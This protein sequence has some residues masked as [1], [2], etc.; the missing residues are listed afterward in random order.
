MTYEYHCHGL[1]L[2][3][4]QMT[5]LK[6]AAVRHEWRGGSRASRA[7]CAT[8][9]VRYSRAEKVREAAS[10]IRTCPICLALAQS[11]TGARSLSL[12]M[13]TIVPHTHTQQGR[14]Q[15]GFGPQA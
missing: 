5:P 2:L 12:T 11:T 15:S 13:R 3:R 8:G 14:S 1:V 9:A 6:W 10:S 7:V 4:R